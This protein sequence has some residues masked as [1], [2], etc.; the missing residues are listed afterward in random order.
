MKKITWLLDNGHG[1]DTKGKESPV[2]K[3][4][5]VLFEYE[6]NRDIVGRIANRL[7]I[8]GHSYQILVP[9]LDDITL[10]ERCR[11]ANEYFIN[12]PDEYC[13]LISVHGNAFGNEA[14]SGYEV[15]TSP[16]ETS[17][18][19]YATIIYNHALPLGMKARSDYS[20]GDPDKEDRFYI[21]IHTKMSAILT[22]SG[23]YTNEKECKKMLTDRFREDIAAAHYSAMLEIEGLK[24]F[25]DG[26]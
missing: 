5:S 24:R 3:D 11:R 22:E 17:S 14:A 13:I 7:E 16:G 15:Y 9:E 18:D 12:H 2:W 21:L 23:F 6:F 1:I 26:K 25:K 10:S 19:K 20:D 4:G 8:G